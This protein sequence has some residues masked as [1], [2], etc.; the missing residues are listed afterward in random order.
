M[1]TFPRHTDAQGWSA[2]FLKTNII[3]HQLPVVINQNGGQATEVLVCLLN[4]YFMLCMSWGKEYEHSGGDLLC[5]TEVY[6]TLLMCILMVC[7]IS[8]VLQYRW[9]ILLRC[10]NT[11]VYII[12][13]YIIGEYYWYAILLMCYST[14]VYI[15]DVL[16]YWFAILLMRYIIDVLYYWCAIL[17]MCYIIEIKGLNRPALCASSLIKDR[18]VMMSDMANA[19]M[20][21]F[22]I[23]KKL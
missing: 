15:N 23:S 10:Y 12:D 22:E 19:T 18:M 11:D 20:S 5:I 16:Y 8:D 2:Q 17:F 1:N 6:I 14:V 21:T 9:V 13:A 7:Y 4:C 3:T